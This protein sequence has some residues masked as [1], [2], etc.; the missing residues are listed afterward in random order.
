MI[1]SQIIYAGENTH[2]F[3]A[4]KLKLKDPDFLF[5]WNKD[6]S[7]YLFCCFTDGLDKL[8]SGPLRQKLLRAVQ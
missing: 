4:N 2:S 7:P 3:K 6:S 5:P 1:G 8:P